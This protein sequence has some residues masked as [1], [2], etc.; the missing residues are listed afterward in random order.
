MEAAEF[1]GAGNDVV[2]VPDEASGT[3]IYKRTALHP[4]LE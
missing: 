2:P 4:G 3:G 1:Y